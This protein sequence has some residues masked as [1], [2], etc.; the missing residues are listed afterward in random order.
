MSELDFLLGVSPAQEE[1]VTGGPA[2]SRASATSGRW[3]AS[4]ILPIV[5]YFTFVALFLLVPT[6]VLFTKAFRPVTGSTTSAMVEAM[7][8]SNRSSFMFSLK[9]SLYSAVL[10]AIIGFLFALAA[11]RIERPR[12]LRNLV[13]GFSGVAANLGGIPLAFA[14]IASLG[15]QG[16][17]T[18][19]M[20]HYG[21]DLYGAGFKIYDFWGIVVVYLY[22]QIPLMLLVMLPAIDGLR[23]TWR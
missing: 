9:L 22:F 20:Y 21:I 4:V 18:R 16:L 17:F 6:V 2:G 19:I 1:N 15:A 7:N 12:R 3:S 8:T 10:G 5:P 13:T 11:S 23:P 14:F